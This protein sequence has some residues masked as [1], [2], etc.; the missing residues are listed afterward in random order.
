MLTLQ[1]RRPTSFLPVYSLI[2]AGLHLWLVYLLTGAGREW[3]VFDPVA[4][5]RFIPIALATLLGLGSLAL[6]ICAGVY[7]W[8]GTRTMGLTAFRLCV[9][10]SL[11]VLYALLH[12]AGHW[13]GFL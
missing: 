6:T 8:R 1:T 10:V 9:V 2:L 3:I 11:A 13:L 12:C 5:F 4:P 7:R